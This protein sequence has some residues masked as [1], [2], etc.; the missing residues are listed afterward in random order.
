MLI[1]QMGDVAQWL[2]SQNRIRRPW[3]R[4]PS[5]AGYQTIILSLRVNSC[6]DFVV[7]DPSPSPL[8]VYGMHPNCA[9]V[10]NPISIFSKRTGLTARGIGTRKDYTRK[11][12]FKLGNVVLWLLAFARKSIPKFPC[13]A[14]GNERYVI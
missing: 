13:I 6:A 2:E 9:H 14:L 10:K 7:P 1:P 11:R 4:S 3:V 5:G 8:R 12:K